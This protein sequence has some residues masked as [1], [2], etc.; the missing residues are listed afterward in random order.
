MI[1]YTNVG[2]DDL[3]WVS[4]EWRK[5]NDGAIAGKLQ[6]ETTIDVNSNSLLELST[7]IR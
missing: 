3:G 2:Y 5:S 4:I 6:L 1:H 7:T